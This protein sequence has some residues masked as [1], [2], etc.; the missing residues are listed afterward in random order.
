MKVGRMTID[1]E[2][3]TDIGIS[4]FGFISTDQIPFLPQIREICEKN[5][6]RSYGATWACPPAV[7]TFKECKEKCLSFDSAMV[8]N[9]VY[10]LEDSFDFEGMTAAHKA[11]KTVC[12]NLYGLVNA[13][14][15][16]FL[17]LSN[18]SCIR[19][20]KCT[21]PDSPCRFPDILFP[22]IEGFGILVATLADAAKIAYINGR[23][24]V[25]YFGMLLY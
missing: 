10:P 3:L 21:Y 25:T 23:N 1:S 13:Q 22:S 19:C 14:M 7:G 18:E 24:T 6:C 20:E 12:D 15:T 11:F 4:H 17:L 16:D 5:S 2:Q 9:G 8:F